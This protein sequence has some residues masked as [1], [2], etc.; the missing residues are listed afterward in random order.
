MSNLRIGQYGVFGSFDYF[1]GRAAEIER[2]GYGAIWIG[3]SPPAD[4]ALIE[5]ALAES[6]RIVVASGIVNVWTAPVGEVVESYHRLEERHPG[7]FL[8]GIGAGHPEHQAEYQSPYRAV[9][10]YLDA[11]AAGGVPKERIVLAALRGRMLELAAE[12][13]A[14]AH[15]YFMPVAHTRLARERLGAGPLLATEAKVVFETDPAKAHA[16]GGQVSSFYLGLRNYV[17]AWRELGFPDLE[18]GAPPTEAWLDALVSYGTP[19]GIVPGLRAHLDA[20]A[21]HVAVQVIPTA[22]DPIPGLA[23]LAEQLRLV[24]GAGA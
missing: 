20:G 22:S 18:V 7:R 21:D 2:L 11:L 16:V 17:N 6:E 13:T 10:A 8:L 23:A 19:A 9:V 12:R 5:A 24:A 15:P 4:L 3:G 1:K 14:G